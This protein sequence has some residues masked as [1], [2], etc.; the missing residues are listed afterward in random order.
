[1]ARTKT[2]YYDRKSKGLCVRCGA[3]PVTGQ[4]LCLSCKEKM[5][6]TYLRYYLKNLEHVRKIKRRSKNKIRAERKKAGLCQF[7]A[8]PLDPDMDRGNKSCLN[9]LKYNEDMR[10]R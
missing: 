3:P 8:V 9:C 5:R 2:Q 10:S 6:I 7:C 4:T 1:M